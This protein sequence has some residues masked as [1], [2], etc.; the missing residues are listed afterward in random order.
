MTSFETRLQAGLVGESIPIVYSFLNKLKS[1]QSSG[2]ALS[3][4][5]TW[6]SQTTSLATFDVGSGALTTSEQ[7]SADGFTNDACIGRFT[8]VAAGLCTVKVT[9]AGVNPTATWVG[10][11]QF[12]ISDVPSP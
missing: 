6:V 1:F 9:I 3:G 5:P 10:Y 12:D 2:H 4:T 8:M 7:G 11:I